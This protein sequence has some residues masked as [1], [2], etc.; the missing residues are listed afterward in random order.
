MNKAFS[1]PTHDTKSIRLNNS[2]IGLLTSLKEDTIMTKT[3]RQP[4]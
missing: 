2:G 4:K 1:L 3:K